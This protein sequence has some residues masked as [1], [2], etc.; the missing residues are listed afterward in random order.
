MED[1]QL[2]ACRD[3]FEKWANSLFSAYRCKRYPERYENY[4]F[5]RE[6][7][8][9]QAAYTRPKANT[10]ARGAQETGAAHTGLLEIIDSQ[11]QTH[12]A[13]IKKVK[14]AMDAL[15]FYADESINQHNY[16]S[17]MGT[18]LTATARTALSQ[19]QQEKQDV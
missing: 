6:W 1:N 3:A 17:I 19:I 11:K 18:D 10:E 13:L 4:V 8:S 2:K 12:S 15:Q 7:V 16:H 14:I 5:Q 9:W